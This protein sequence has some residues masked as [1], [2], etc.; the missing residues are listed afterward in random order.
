MST[1]HGSSIKIFLPSGTTDGLWVVE[2]SNWTGR[3]IVAPRSSISLLLEREEVLGAGV[4][5][6]IGPAESASKTNRIYVGEAEGL[7]SRLKQQESA[8]DFWTRA[9]IFTAGSTSLNK[10]RVKYIESRLIDLAMSSGRSEVENATVPKIPSLSE[11]DTAEVEGFLDEMLVIYPVLGLSAFESI[12]DEH[13]S[14]GKGA[15]L[16]LKGP[17]TDASG[18]EVADGFVVLEGSRGRLSTVPSLNPSILNLRDDLKHE[19]VLEESGDCIILQKDFVFSSPSTA[20]AVF[21]GRTANGRSEWR[22][23][24][25]ISLGKVQDGY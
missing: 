14:A 23:K 21:L 8:K 11:A 9:I 15:T 7:K 4:Y 25:G 24:D 20:A 6:L 17:C 22:T 2:L 19:G 5:V 1:R 13:S 12:R 16:H 10:A 3:A 18:S